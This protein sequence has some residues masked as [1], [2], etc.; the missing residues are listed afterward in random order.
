[1]LLP[2]GTVSFCFTD[3][4]G[5]TRRW[6]QDPTMADALARHDEVLRG[7]VGACGG[8]VLKHTGDGALAVFGSAV[9]AVGAAVSLQRR[10]SESSP[11]KVRVAVHT[12]E[13]EE[14]DGDYFGPVLNRAARLLS[15]A[16]G[17]QVLV[18]LATEELARDRLPTGVGLVD[19]GEHWLRDL[20]Q[21]ERVF[22][23]TAEGL[24]ERF[25]PLRAAV[26]VPSN[27]PAP[28]TS[29]VGREADLA[30]I[31]ARLEQGRLV[32]LVGVGGAGKTRLGIEA[33]RR[34]LGGFGDGVFFVD[35]SSVADEAGVALRLAE[36]LAVTVPQGVVAGPAVLREVAVF[37]DDGRVLVV[38]DNCEHLLDVCAELVDDLLAETP[39]VRV[40]AT[41]RE[42]L[43]I[44]GEQVLAVRSLS[45]PDR[46]EP[47]RDSDAVRLLVER[48]GAVRPGFEV[49]DE[50]RWVLEEICRHL[51][52][53]PLALE[54]AAVRARHLGP[55]EILERL[56]D[57]FAL[58]TGG[59]R[60]SQRHQTLQATVDW[61]FELLDPDEQVVLRRLA[62]FTGGFTLDAVEGICLKGLAGPALDLVGS[63]VDKSLVDTV[64]GDRFR[65]LETI[66][67]YAQD[68]LVT[69]GE[70]DTVR[71]G[72][73][74]WFLARLEAEPLERCL[75]S[76]AFAV[77]LVNDADN[78]RAALAWCDAQGRHDLLR[79]LLLRV[80]LPLGWTDRSG[81][82]ND[83]VRRVL[84]Y[85][86]SLPPQQWHCHVRAEAPWPGGGGF[87]GDPAE[88][89]VALE[90][91]S[92]L[93]EA[94]PSGEVITAFAHLQQAQLLCV[95]PKRAAEIVQAAE[96]AVDHAGAQ[97]HL[98]TMH[99]QWRKA[100]ARLYQ[101]RYDEAAELLEALP[102]DEE[103]S[104]GIAL[105]VVHHLR[106]RHVEASRVLDATRTRVN[107]TLRRGE[108]VIG[109][110]TAAAVGD[111]ATARRELADLVGDIRQRRDARHPLAL[112]DCLVGIAALAGVDGD[113]ERAAVSI[114]AVPAMATS[115]PELLLLLRHYRDLAREHL[116]RDLRRRSIEQG[117][118][119]AVDDAIDAELARWDS[120]GT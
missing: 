113:H 46:D 22:Q 61:S 14:R 94:L 29:F 101:Y 106:G 70:A 52:G 102:I 57:R 114:A 91:L 96:R 54:L 66:R 39:N 118:S 37:L 72:H 109:A 71:S 2:S 63:L 60:R 87:Q 74:D 44:E 116:D 33:A 4:E 20:T 43:A 26:E 32:T 105:A 38:L 115:T 23:V 76:D 93:A 104:Y 3:I 73:R 12:G 120:D 77:G 90:R 11:F 81:R 58:L 28:R 56:A 112:S 68:K 30:E 50:N 95:F 65:L 98:L 117:R 17:G 40:L 53:I 67:A 9:D 6:E 55:A 110:V 84:D 78:L 111:R 103:Q 79:R 49:T 34:A 18:S 92:A 107:A 69:A 16:H 80:P 24:E 62:V 86:R 19:L 25:A 99:A 5:S 42:A 13:A 31:A 15:L 89:E 35:L 41:S 7:V 1:V 97:N 21:P 64:E 100:T 8:Q 119:T 47:D 36:S 85:E 83:W 88:I 82:Y 75:L 51:D 10:L 48:I 108:Q 59:R 27:L 45:L